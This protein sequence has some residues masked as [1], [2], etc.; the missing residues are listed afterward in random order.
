MDLGYR[1]TGEDV[2]SLNPS[3]SEKKEQFS[4]RSSED[5]PVAQSSRLRSIED[6]FCAILML[7]MIAAGT[8]SVL[9]RFWSKL[10]VVGRWL[11]GTYLNWLDPLSQHLVLWVALF[12]AGAAAAERSHIAIDV[13]IYILP[14]KAKRMVEVLTSFV[15]AGICILLTWLS[16]VFALDE[17]SHGVE[18][19]TFLG[20]KASWLPLIIP[21]GFLILSLRSIVVL[22]ENIRRLPAVPGETAHPSGG[23]EG[24][25]I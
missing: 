21:V 23:K 3:E 22:I 4:G 13:L 12:G 19:Y 9:N 11:S 1:S 14:K 2:M 18:E 16:L 8:I 24:A 25:G 7:T 6:W 5:V 10:P 15:T 20:L 17:F